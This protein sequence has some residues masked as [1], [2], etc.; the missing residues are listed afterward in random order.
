MNKLEELDKLVPEEDEIKE[1]KS[2]KKAPETKKVKTE[3]PKEQPKPEKKTGT[4]P[5][6][7]N[8]KKELRAYIAENYEDKELPE[9]L[10]VAELRKWY[11]IVQEGGE[12]PF[13]DYEESENEEAG[14]GDPEP[15]DTAVDEQEVSAS[16][17]NSSAS[18]LRSLKARTSK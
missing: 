2:P 10:T 1:R 15:E 18:R 17:P 14:V 6:L 5:T 8:L 12:L 3:E 11:D 7:T 4:Y 9:E 13:E 16:V